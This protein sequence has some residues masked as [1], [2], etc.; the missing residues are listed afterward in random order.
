MSQTPPPG[1]VAT[2]DDFKHQRDEGGDLVGIWQPIPGTWQDCDVCDGT[3]V[4]SLDKGLDDDEYEADEC[5]NCGG[6]GGYQKHVKVR[7]ITQGAANKY[8]PS[9]GSMDGLDD[10]SICRIFNQFV[11]EPDFELNPRDA[12]N[13][14]EDFTAFGVEPLIMAIYKASGFDMVT[15]TMQDNAEIAELAQEIEGNMNNGNSGLE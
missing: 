2:K 11:V 12:E 5:E 14:L 4:E 15:G 6:Q 3:G 13:E 1:A 7:P 8:L 10:E 9:D